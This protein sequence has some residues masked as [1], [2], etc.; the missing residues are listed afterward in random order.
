MPVISAAAIRIRVAALPTTACRA[1]AKAKGESNTV[2][3]AQGSAPPQE[4]IE[5]WPSG[6]AWIPACA[7]MT[8]HRLFEVLKLPKAGNGV[9]SAYLFVF[10]AIV[11]VLELL[12]AHPVW[13]VALQRSQDAVI[14]ANQGKVIRRF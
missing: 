6:S 4:S 8:I 12:Q 7:G 14:M 3:P 2:I 1:A 5:R 9:S 11:A 10:S 13:Y